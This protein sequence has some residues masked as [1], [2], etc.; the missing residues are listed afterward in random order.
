MTN[1]DKMLGKEELVE[2]HVAL[3]KVEKVMDKLRDVKNEY[4]PGFLML[5]LLGQERFV[6]FS[7]F[8]IVQD[9]QVNLVMSIELEVGH[10]KDPKIMDTV[11]QVMNN[12]LVHFLDMY[13]FQK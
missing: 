8:A 11:D 5:V 13:Q 2:V 7:Q 10:H 1:V 12:T 6:K 3:D 4:K 9:A